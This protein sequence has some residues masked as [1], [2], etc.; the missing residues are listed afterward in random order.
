MDSHSL[1]NFK[2]YLT[3]QWGLPEDSIEQLC[4]GLVTKKVKKEE[5]LLRA[6]EVCALTFFV[7]KGL[8]RMYALNEKGKVDILQFAPENWLVSDRGSVYFNEPSNYYIDA[9]EESTVVL[10]DQNFM[11]RISQLGHSFRKLNER[12]L[13]NHI[14]HLNQRVKLLLGA[15]AETR[16]LN[17]IHLYPDIL[18][19]VT[20]WMVASYLG[21][22]P[23]S[24]SRVR[25]DLAKRNFK[26]N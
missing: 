13:H 15:S 2:K 6:G 14:R 11:E 19:R 4:D 22:A 7:E 24:L 8:L 25:R 16:Y 23:E 18:I 9:I 1:A 10:L 12:L 17:F 21:I 26:K 20:Q 3:E 5:Y